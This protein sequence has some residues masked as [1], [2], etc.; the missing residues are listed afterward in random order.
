MRRLPHSCGLLA[1]TL[2][3][4]CFSWQDDDMPGADVPLIACLAVRLI[5]GGIDD[6]DRPS[7]H[8]DRD[9]YVV[10]QRPQSSAAG[11][12]ARGHRGEEQNERDRG[13]GY[14]PALWSRPV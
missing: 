13:A 7:A 8:R 12:L 4:A 10:G 3:R 14:G 2:V 11:G 6:H 1:I 5:Q 9:A